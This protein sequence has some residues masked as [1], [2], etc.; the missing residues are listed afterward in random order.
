MELRQD[1]RTPACPDQAHERPARHRSTP[2]D[3]GSHVVD[4]S[5]SVTRTMGPVLVMGIEGLPA[6]QFVPPIFLPSNGNLQVCI[7]LRVRLERLRDKWFST[8][9]VLAHRP[10]T[11][12]RTCLS[13]N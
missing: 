13:L 10:T 6:R 2:G 4:L 11:A 12:K 5:A 7:D 8:S 9:Q 1:T 3:Y